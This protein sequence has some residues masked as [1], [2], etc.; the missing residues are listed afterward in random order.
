MNN[1]IFTDTLP[2]HTTRLVS[3]L[4][5]QKPLFLSSFYL[6]GGTGLSLQLG[7]RES[8]DLDFFSRD[9]FTPQR[10][11]MELTPFGSLRQTE[12][13]EGTL[14]TFLNEVKLQ[15]LEYPYPLLQPFVEWKGIQLSS[16][17]DIGCTK[18]QTI[19]MRGSKKDFVDLYFLLEKHSLEDLLLYAQVKY[20]QSDYSQ[21]HIIKSLVYFEDA[22]GQPMPRMH[23]PVQWEEIKEKIILEV[24]S[25][26]LI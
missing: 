3:Q 20:A 25:L 6:S 22:E 8:E 2:K 24:K 18:L 14:N 21:T 10:L 1:T 5:T 9:S 17:L 16:V 13:A 19:S 7:H 15:F 23:K 4:Q 26:S 11:E 12:F